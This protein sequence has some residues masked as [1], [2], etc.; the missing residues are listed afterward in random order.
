MLDK[1]GNVKM[2]ANRI[3]DY[4]NEHHE[5]HKDS[6]AANAV[7]ISCD[8]KLSLETQHKRMSHLNSKDLIT[9]NNN[10]ALKGICIKKSDKEKE[11]EIYLK[12]KMTRLPLPVILA[13]S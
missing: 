4:T 6:I 11:C 5:S 9:A 7:N 2:T 3:G 13:W 8:S 10:R 12:G 1:D